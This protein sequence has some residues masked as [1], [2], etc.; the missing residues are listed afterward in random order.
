AA[1]RARSR[2][3]APLGRP[4]LGRGAAQLAARPRRPPPR[5]QHQGPV[6]H[7]G[8]Q[9]RAGPPP[10]PGPGGAVRHER[11]SGG[12]GKNLDVAEQ[13]LV[14]TD[15]DITVRVWR[16]PHDPWL[17]MLPQVCYPDIVGRTLHDLGV[18][19]GPDPSEPIAIDVVSYRPGRRAV[20][21]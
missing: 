12:R 17:P 19:L 16:Y 13:T 9:A 4:Q 10:G 8:L 2:W 1:H 15:G 20:L 11:H 3:A 18:S 7:P 21:R 14:M 5:P 6:P